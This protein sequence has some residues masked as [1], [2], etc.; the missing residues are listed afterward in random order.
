MVPLTPVALHLLV[1][2][3]TSACGAQL[4]NSWC[5]TAQRGILATS[6]IL[7]VVL[8]SCK[9]A[10]ASFWQGLIIADNLCHSCSH[11]LG[12]GCPLKAAGGQEGVVLLC[13]VAL[14][15]P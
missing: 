7:L 14:R 15:M 3:G 6:C 11:R 8:G 2:P 13:F 9:I 10:V 1:P 4:S 5:E 12:W